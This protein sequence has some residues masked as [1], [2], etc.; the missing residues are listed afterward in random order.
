[1]ISAARDSSMLSCSG[2]QGRIR[3]RELVLYLLPGE[4]GLGESGSREQSRDQNCI[5]RTSAKERRG[6][7]CGFRDLHRTEKQLQ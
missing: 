2:L 6:S 3:S 4:G 5:A 1:M 7:R